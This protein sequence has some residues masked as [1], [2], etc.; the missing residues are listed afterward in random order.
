VRWYSPRDWIESSDNVTEETSPDQPATTVANSNKP[1]INQPDV[2]DNG[3]ND[4]VAT[5][6]QPGVATDNQPDV[7]TDNQNDVATD[8]QPGV[9]TDNQP[10]VATD[11]QPGVATDNQPDVAT[12]NQLDNGE[13]WDE[14]WAMVEEV[15]SVVKVLYA[16]TSGQ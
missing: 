15:T 10:D 13:G 11:N 12:D 3:C 1:V 9:A 8:N 5:D 14:E 6:N 4:D 16:Y 2:I 7:A